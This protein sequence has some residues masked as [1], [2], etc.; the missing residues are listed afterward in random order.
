M[1]FTTPQALDVTSCP[2]LALLRKLQIQQGEVCDN[3]TAYVLPTLPIQVR[4]PELKRFNGGTLYVIP[5]CMISYL[6]YSAV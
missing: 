6:L 1:A 5:G 2:Q 3:G 4:G